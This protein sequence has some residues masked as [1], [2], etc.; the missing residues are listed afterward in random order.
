MNRWFAVA[1]L[2]FAMNSNAQTIGSW[3]LGTNA[4]KS[5]FAVSINESGEGLML[6]CRIKHDACY[7][8]VV[9]SSS[10]E[11]GN[12]YPSMISSTSG[13]SQH[14]LICEGSLEVG[15]QTKYR[16]FIDG[17]ESMA[18]HIATEA[19]VALVYPL[20]GGQFRVLR[21]ATKGGPKAVQTVADRA[22][23]ARPNAAE[24]IL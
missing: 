8:Y 6:A 22:I 23:K 14:K 18:Q 16:L 3:S 20:D 10:C 13:T 2:A 7:W 5:P 17:Y 4:E 1:A 12:S 21:F 9:M 24:Q 19:T 11:A 15:G